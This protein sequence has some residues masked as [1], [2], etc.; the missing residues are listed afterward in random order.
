MDLV[1]GQRWGVAL[2]LG[3]GLAEGFGEGWGN[4]GFEHRQRLAQFHGRALELAEHLEQL[5]GRLLHHLGVDLVLGLTGQPFPD[6]ECGTTGN[7]GRKRCEFCGA[8]GAATTNLSHELHHAGARMI[9]TTQ[10]FPLG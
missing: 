1:R 7:T 5:F 3:Q 10:V 8:R 4:G 2:Q 6:T 9:L